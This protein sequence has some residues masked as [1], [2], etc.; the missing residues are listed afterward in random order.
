MYYYEV[1]RN[2]SIAKELKMKVHSMYVMLHK[3]FMVNSL[4]GY[5]ILNCIPSYYVIF[6]KVFCLIK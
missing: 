4:K 6:F 3:S 5:S 2:V 1:Y